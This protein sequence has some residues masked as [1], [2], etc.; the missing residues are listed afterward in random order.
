MQ[1]GISIHMK[2]QKRCENS[3]TKRALVGLAN[4][5]AELDFGRSTGTERMPQG[6]A[7]VG[8][9][10]REDRGRGHNPP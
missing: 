2:I 6:G 10:G 9:G 1:H 8:Q 3:K 7:A 4:L 5:R